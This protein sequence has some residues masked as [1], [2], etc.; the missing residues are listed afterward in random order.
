VRNAS[1]ATTADIDFTVSIV[2]EHLAFICRTKFG[3]DYSAL[4][5][6]VD[7]LRFAMFQAAT[8]F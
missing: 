6:S 7:T 5:N 1:T 4:R 8:A 2:A 3:A